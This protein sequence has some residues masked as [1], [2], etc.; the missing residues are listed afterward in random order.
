MFST[1]APS[2]RLSRGSGGQL[3]G[4]ASRAVCSFMCLCE[5][6]GVLTCSQNAA[7]NPVQ[8]KEAF[9]NSRHR[10]QRAQPKKCTRSRFHSRSN[11]PPELSY[12]PSDNHMAALAPRNRSF[13]PFANRSSF[14]RRLFVVDVPR[15]PAFANGPVREP[16]ANCSFAVEFARTH[17]P[18]P[19]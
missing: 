6:N 5:M 13:A 15:G 1:V 16:F 2:T 18:E 8:A 4:S 10:F 7:R 3:E 19:T 12:R 11:P 14:V 9:R 17:N